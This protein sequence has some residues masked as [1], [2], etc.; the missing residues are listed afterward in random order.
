MKYFRVTK[1]N[2]DYRDSQGR[3]TEDDWTSYSDIGMKVTQKEY[4]QVESAYIDTALKFLEEQNIT[5]L[6]LSYLEN[7]LN[8]QEP[9]VS[10]KNGTVLNFNALKQ[11]MKSI[12]R[13]KYWAKLEAENSFVHFGYDYYM[14]IGVPNE[15]RLVWELAKLNGLYVEECLSPYV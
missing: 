10:L 11:V 9:G 15:P 8:N 14:Y 7:R 6:K 13:E 1:Y 5:E 4:E 12:L 2:P 3:Y